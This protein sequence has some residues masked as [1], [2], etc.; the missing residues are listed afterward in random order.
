MAFSIA[1]AVDYNYCMKT[2]RQLIDEAQELASKAMGNN[3]LGESYII[4]S[5]ALLVESNA[6]VERG[7][8][9]LLNELGVFNKKAERQAKTMIMLTRAIVVLTILTLIGLAVQIWLSIH[10]SSH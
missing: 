9:L 7:I 2:Q 8:S 3:R 10:T 4:E 6:N 1:E 5:N